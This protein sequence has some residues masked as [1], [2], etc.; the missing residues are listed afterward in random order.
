MLSFLCVVKKHLR[1]FAVFLRCGKIETKAVGPQNQQTPPST[2]QQ[3]E[4]ITK[5]GFA[6]CFGNDVWY[7]FAGRIF[8]KFLSIFRG[9]YFFVFFVCFSRVVFLYFFCILYCFCTFVFS[10]KKRSYFPEKCKFSA[11]NCEP[12]KPTGTFF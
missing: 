12:A 8:S 5:F 11:S 1:E 3:N 2:R 7:F 9:S 6:T 10:Y 4:K